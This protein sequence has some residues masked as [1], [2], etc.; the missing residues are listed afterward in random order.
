[1]ENWRSYLKELENTSE[2]GMPKKFYIS[3]RFGKDQEQLMKDLADGKVIKHQGQASSGL[4]G[5]ADNPSNFMQF[6]GNIR[7][8][9][10]VMP[11]ADF[12]ELNDSIVKIEYDNPD[13]LAQ[14]GLKA[15]YRLLEK[16][17]ED[18][19][20]APRILGA[21]I[22]GSDLTGTMKKV[23]G[24]APSPSEAHAMQTLFGE[25]E[26]QESLAKI[27]FDNLEKVY[28]V[29]SL[30]KLLTPPLIAY[31]KDKSKLDSWRR[32]VLEPYLTPDFVQT[33]M[34]AGVLGAARYYKEENEWVVDSNVLNVPSSSI[35]YVAG[36]TLKEKSLFQKM[37]KGELTEPQKD[38]LSYEVK[39]MNDIVSSIEEYGLDKKYKKV[40]ITDLGTFN[41][42]KNK[43]QM[44]KRE[45]AHEL[46]KEELPKAAE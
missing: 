43:W 28:D 21:I 24:K 23:S 41:A 39:K 36:P 25:H 33:I 14:D 30:S 34:R 2:V 17:Q 38:V 40:I 37:K 26:L 8:A 13:F 42:A 7:D 6:H 15:L 11:G 18:Q 5:F 44:R 46:E 12:A 9:T 3:I 22:D 16:N 32:E 10:I 1:M 20:H 45:I 19:L 4:V 35:I 27:L 31:S 29:D